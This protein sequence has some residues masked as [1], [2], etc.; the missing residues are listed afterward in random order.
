MYR[1]NY[2]RMTAEEI[3]KNELAD[4]TN[5][6]SMEDTNDGSQLDYQNYD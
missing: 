5:T 1:R 4:V 3:L 6:R 2:L